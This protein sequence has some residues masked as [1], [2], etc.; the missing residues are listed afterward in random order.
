MPT[1]LLPHA[2]QKAAVLSPAMSPAPIEPSKIDQQ[3]PKVWRRRNGKESLDVA[4][5]SLIL[6]N[7]MSE[8]D[9]VGQEIWR[10]APT[11]SS[12]E[13][14]TCVSQS[15]EQPNGVRLVNSFKVLEE[16]Q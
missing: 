10:Q 7:A 14:N 12:F 8:D 6:I 4:I 2:L 15:P 11:K 16:L 1:E 9:G 5:G 3:I 13:Q